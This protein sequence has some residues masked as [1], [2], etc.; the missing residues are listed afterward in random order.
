METIKLKVVAFYT[1]FRHKITKI[2]LLL[3]LIPLE[4]E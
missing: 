1:I 2:L 4:L 3:T